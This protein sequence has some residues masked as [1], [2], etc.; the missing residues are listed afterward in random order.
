MRNLQIRDA[1]YAKTAN[2]AQCRDR[3]SSS[4][5]ETALGIFDRVDLRW[6]NGRVHIVNAKAWSVRLTA[7]SRALAN[8]EWSFSFHRDTGR[9]SLA[10]AAIAPGDV[11]Q[12]TP[13]TW[14][15]GECE[16]NAAI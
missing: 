9:V 7:V 15:R 8:P 13:S 12:T 6:N 10:T 16:E 11:E 3:H 2:A 14:M 1:Q 4:V 5:P